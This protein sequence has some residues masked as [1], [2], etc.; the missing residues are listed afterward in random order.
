[1]NSRHKKFAL[2]ALTAG[3]A[4]VMMAPAANAASCGA[5]MDGLATAQGLFGMGT[6]YA[7]SAAVSKWAEKVQAR[8]GIY[9]A[10]FDNARGVRWNC[11]AGAILQARCHVS[12]VPCRL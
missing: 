2:S 4:A 9:Y 10:N 12:A 8:Y 3:L 5:R 11:K 6:A 1:M 7:R